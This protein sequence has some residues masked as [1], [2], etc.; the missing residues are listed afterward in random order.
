MRGGHV[1]EAA[2]IEWER[3]V[4]RGQ[5]K[6][7]RSQAELDRIYGVL[8]LDRAEEIVTY[9]QSGIRASHTYF[10]LRYLGYKNV[11]VYDGSW[12][13]WG[14]DLSTPIDK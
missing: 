7:L 4:T 8:S 12:A 5:I 14:N 3:A 10:T 1:P 6:V 13:E 2:N 9:C 11:R